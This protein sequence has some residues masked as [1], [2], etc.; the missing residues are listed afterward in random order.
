MK[1]LEEKILR[2]FKTS[3]AMSNFEEEFLMKKILKKQIITV[4]ILVVVL[5]SGGLLT[6]N[7]AT[8]GKVVEDIKETI[9]NMLKD[10]ANVKVDSNSIEI[11][12]IKTDDEGNV[13][14]VTYTFDTVK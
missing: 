5:F 4:S 2:N 10:N 1:D 11:Q 7:A 9:Y 14:S 13:E 6:V 3:V 12:D 8:D